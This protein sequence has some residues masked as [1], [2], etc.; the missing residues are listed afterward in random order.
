MKVLILSNGKFETREIKGTLKDFQSIVGGYI[1]IP[2]ICNGFI[3]NNIDIIINEEG[4]LIDG[5][6]PEIVL[7]DD[8]TGD[9]IDIVFGNCIFV[10]NDN[11][12]NNISITDEQ[13]KFVKDALREFGILNNGQPIRLLFV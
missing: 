1:E 2:F 7:V 3:D 12:G 4:K 6:N 8:V 10:G 9:S 11:E 5:M 13:I